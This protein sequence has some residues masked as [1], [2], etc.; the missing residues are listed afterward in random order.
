VGEKLAWWLGI[1]SPKYYY[2]IQ[3]ALRIKVTI[4]LF[5]ISCLKSYIFV[6]KI[7]VLYSTMPIFCPSNSSV[8]VDAGIE[9]RSLTTLEWQSEAL[10]TQLDLI[11]H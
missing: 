2:E 7:Y 6:K 11:H 4:S 3:E 8:S 1:T 10:T 5:C 9:P